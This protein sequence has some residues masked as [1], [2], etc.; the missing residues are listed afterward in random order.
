[1]IVFDDIFHNLWQ[2]L[3]WLAWLMKEEEKCIR[4]SFS[5]EIAFH[6]VLLTFFFT[7]I[8]Y[9]I[10]LFN[11]IVIVVPLLSFHSSTRL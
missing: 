9:T 2:S 11:F 4:K 1:M 7:L 10:N 8:H 3:A 5:L 6:D